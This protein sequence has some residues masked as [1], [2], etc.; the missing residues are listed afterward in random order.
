MPQKTCLVI[1]D[2]RSVRTI[3]RRM[4][5]GLG[6][7]VTEAADGRQGLAVYRDVLPDVILLDWN[8]PVLDGLGFLGGLRAAYGTDHPPV[9]FCTTETSGERI[10]EAITA[11][12]AEYI[13]KPFDETIIAGKLAQVG[14]LAGTAS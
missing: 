11:G 5:E 14:V 12:A 4:L 6:L 13:M 7:R 9:I 10:Q 2:S 8:M 1:D 3:A